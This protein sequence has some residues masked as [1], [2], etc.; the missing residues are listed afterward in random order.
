MHL[1]EKF[2]NPTI[3]LLFLFILSF[4]FITVSFFLSS[5][6]S[7]SSSLL[8]PFPL[9]RVSLP[10][11]F[12]YPLKFDRSVPYRSYPFR[13]SC[14]SKYLSVRPRYAVI[15]QT[16]L[17]EY[18]VCRLCDRIWSERGKLRNNE[19]IDVRES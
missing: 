7:Y 12:L 2:Q 18:S 6:S 17:Y 5:S 14:L 3:F 19:V 16:L 9:F 1:R 8:F 15:K 11:V 4:L 10:N 13:C